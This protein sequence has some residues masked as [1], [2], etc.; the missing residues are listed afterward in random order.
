MKKDPIELLDAEGVAGILGSTRKGVYV[1]A[2]RGLIPRGTR[3]PGV[4]L[5]WRRDALEAW[6]ASKMQGPE[7][8]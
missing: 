6:I 8:A 5:R 3:L 1:A 7:A 4:G 2:Q